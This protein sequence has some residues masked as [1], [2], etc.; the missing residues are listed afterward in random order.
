MDG[1]GTLDILDLTQ[2]TAKVYR[3]S[4]SNQGVMKASVPGRTL[5]GD[6]NCDGMINAADV[7]ALAQYLFH[8]G[9]Q[10]C[11]V[12]SEATETPDDGSTQPAQPNPVSTEPKK[13]E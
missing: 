2:L 11:E 7:V 5:H 3:S 8:G 13:D 10:P 6:V 9:E 1:S 12:K 4:G